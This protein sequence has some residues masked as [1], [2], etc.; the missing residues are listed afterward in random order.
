MKKTVAIILCFVLLACSDDFLDQPPDI[1]NSIEI[2]TID[3]LDK[4]F[5]GIQIPY[6]EDQV[7][8]FCTDNAFM[9]QEVLDESFAFSDAQIG[10]YTFATNFDRTQ[11]EKWRRHYQNVLLPNIALELLDENELE[12]NDE[13]LKAQL[14]AEAHFIRAFHFF[15]LAIAYGL[16]PNQTNENELGIVLRQTSS[17]TES[18]KR[19]TLKQTFEFILADL[20]EALKYP[21]QEKKY[22]YRIGIPSVHAL[23]ARIHLYLR[24][25]DQALFHSNE[26]LA[27]YS[28]MVNF[29]ENV[30][31]SNETLWY[32]NFTYP[33]TAFQRTRSSTSIPDFWVDQYYFVDFSNP[34]WNTSPSQELLDLYDPNDIRNLFFIEGWFSRSGVTS[35]TWFTYMNTQVGT[36]LSGPDVPEMYL[37]R[38]ECKARNNDIAGA[39]ADMEMVRINRFHPE[40]YVP[41]PVPTTVKDAVQLIVDERRREAPFKYR[42]MDIKRLNNDP[43]TDSIIITR[44]IN[45]ET[46]TIQ[47]NDRRYARP[48]G[49]DVINLSEGQ[50]Q[51]NTY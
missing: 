51:Q 34:S 7:N 41:T 45:G 4:L 22:F 32:G 25:Y 35:N 38:A 42:L 11:D 14:R 39:M 17:L 29:D 28:P 13:I 3:E 2:T 8:I 44:T 36:R 19:A 23:V 5:N 20:Q 18:L 43:L 24:N 33:N 47:P 30:F 26:A 10:Q 40:D 37:T 50:T 15:E 6:I 12:G 21:T 48:I 1:N 27:G 9:P 31:E 46:I 16:Y 49:Q